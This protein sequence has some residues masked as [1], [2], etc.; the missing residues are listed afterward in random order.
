MV[1]NDA[2]VTHQN[3]I[4]DGVGS[5]SSQRQ[6][7][8]S[9]KIYGRRV[10]RDLHLNIYLRE[11]NKQKY[12][13]DYT[14]LYIFSYEKFHWY[15]LMSI[16]QYQ[17]HAKI[18][19]MSYLGNDYNFLKVRVDFACHVHKIQYEVLFKIFLSLMIWLY[20]YSVITAD[21]LAYVSQCKCCIR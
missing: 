3:F 2:I 18:V 21:S 12:R 20:A 14:K 13:Y 1:N 15:K 7:C 10:I 5:C 16:S 6:L 8:F 9:C 4:L 11:C 19:E 17:M